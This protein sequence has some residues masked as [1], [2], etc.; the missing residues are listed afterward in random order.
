MMEN[1][2]R[3]PAHPGEILSRRYME[4]D[5]LTVAGLARDLGVS[6]KTLSSIVHGHSAVTVDMALRLSRRFATS[7]GLWLNLQQ[8]HDLWKAMQADTGW[9]DVPCPAGAP[10]PVGA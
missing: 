1:F 6:R 9:R 4:L 2:G 10:C 7:P 5:K 3:R 8:R